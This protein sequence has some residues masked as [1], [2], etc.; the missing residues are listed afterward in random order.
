MDEGGPV[1]VRDRIAL[2]AQRDIETSASFSAGPRKRIEVS[3]DLKKSVT[4]DGSRITAA[5]WVSSH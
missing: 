1:S 2:Y 4:R 5:R 3:S